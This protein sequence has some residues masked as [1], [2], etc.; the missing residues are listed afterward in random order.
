MSNDILI[1]ERP[2]G[3]M[4]QRLSELFSRLHS[5]NEAISQKHGT[6]LI[7]AIEE[8]QKTSFYERHLS[9]TKAGH[10]R[11]LL[12]FYSDIVTQGLDSNAVLKTSKKIELVEKTLSD[13]TP[14]LIPLE[15]HVLISE[16]NVSIAQQIASTAQQGSPEEINEFMNMPSDFLERR[17]EIIRLLEQ[18]SQ[19]ITQL[20]ND[21][22]K[23][24]LLKK[25]RLVFKTLGLGYF[26][27]F[28]SDYL[29]LV[30]NLADVSTLNN[31]IITNELLYLNGLAH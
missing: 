16:F 29:E 21:K 15:L 5:V 17:T 19:Y 22:G 20:L 6:H 12:A 31:A 2:S 3:T 26:Y 27:R 8:H 25:S 28:I 4:K 7:S 23:I 9:L 14:I 13:K 24:K 1:I 10:E 18:L 11:E 30:E